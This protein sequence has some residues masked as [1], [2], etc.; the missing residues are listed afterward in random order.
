MVL[1]EAVSDQYK[2]PTGQRIGAVSKAEYPAQ[3]LV[4]FV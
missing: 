1:F 3:C 2:P 4:I